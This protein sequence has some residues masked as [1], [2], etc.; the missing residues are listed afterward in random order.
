MIA[1]MKR[2]IYRCYRDND[3]VSIEVMAEWKFEITEDCNSEDF[4][5]QQLLRNKAPKKQIKDFR[6]RF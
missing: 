4:F 2:M 5:N 6:H 1:R 3:I